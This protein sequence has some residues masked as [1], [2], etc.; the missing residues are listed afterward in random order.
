M[1]LAPCPAALP[2]AGTRSMTARRRR[3][4]QSNAAKIWCVND[5]QHVWASATA[6]GS[7][8]RS[9]I[10]AGRPALPLRGND[11]RQGHQAQQAKVHRQ[12]QGNPLGQPPAPACGQQPHQQHNPSALNTCTLD[13]EAGRSGVQRLAWLAAMPG[14]LRLVR[15][16]R[17]TLLRDEVQPGLAL[18]VPAPWGL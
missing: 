14:V 5:C 7:K 6:A 16:Q 12:P 4:D 2:Q 3:P 18:S 9:G 15:G 11:S 10:H 13:P 8:A 17:H 1:S